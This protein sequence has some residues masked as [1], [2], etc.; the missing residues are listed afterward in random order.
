MFRRGTQA[1]ITHAVVFD[2]AHRAARLKLLPTMAKECRKHGLSFVVA[3]Q[4]A[5]DFD[6]SLFPRWPIAW[7]CASAQQ[8][9]S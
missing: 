5:K 9:R 6:S 2:E 7:R 4:G 3:S 1:R 8:T